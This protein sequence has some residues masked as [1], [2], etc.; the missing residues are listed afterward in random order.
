M[1]LFVVLKPPRALPPSLPPAIPLYPSLSPS[2]HPSLS[3]PLS[4]QPSLSIPPSLPLSLSAPL[5]HAQNPLSWRLPTMLLP[6]T[7]AGGPYQHGRRWQN[8]RRRGESRAHDR[9]QATLQR[10]AR[11]VPLDSVLQLSKGKKNTAWKWWV[12]LYYAVGQI[13]S[14]NIALSLG[15]CVFYWPTCLFC[16]VLYEDITKPQQKMEHFHLTIASSPLQPIIIDQLH[17]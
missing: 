13:M 15:G 8:H 11:S 14:D 4:L 1:P 3:L 9:T 17:A 2:S 7:V 12:N 6:P 16:C 5:S 10:Q